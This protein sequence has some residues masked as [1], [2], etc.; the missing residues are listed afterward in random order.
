MG[1][2]NRNLFV[3]VC[4]ISVE[5]P[6]A[7]I[8]DGNHPSPAW[9]RPVQKRRTPS[10]SVP[11]TRRP[12][13]PEPSPTDNDSQCFRDSRLRESD[14]TMLLADALDNPTS[15]NA[16]LSTQEYLDLSGT[17]SP[18]ISGDS[19][20][21]IHPYNTSENAAFSLPFETLGP[22]TAPFDQFENLDPDTV[23][24]DI[25]NGANNGSAETQW[26]VPFAS[27]NDA[28]GQM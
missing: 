27:G 18:M 14:M 13:V 7:L 15:A 5:L 17:A 8:G 19:G 11:T 22:A 4:H 21:S 2:W 9:L 23:M 28:I 3:L 20:G 25:G 24:L 12:F 6:K 10:P 16:L 1:L 26:D